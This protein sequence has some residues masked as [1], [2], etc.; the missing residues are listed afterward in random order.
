[1]SNGLRH[2]SQMHAVPVFSYI[3]D[4]TNSSEA[5]EN[6]HQFYQ[7]G[8][9][10]D[11]CLDV[12]YNQ[13]MVKEKH[14]KKTRSDTLN[15]SISSQGFSDDVGKRREYDRVGSCPD[16]GFVTISE[17]NLRT[18]PSHLPPPS[19]PPPVL[20]T[21]MD[22]SSG[23]GSSK[24]S[25]SLEGTEG[26]S[27]PSFFDVEADASS[28]AAAAASSA[29][30]K[31][32]VAKAR[33]QLRNAKELMERKQD[34]FQSRA[35]MTS[36]SDLQEARR[37]HCVDEI[38]KG[39]CQRDSNG[40]K[41]P[42]LEEKQNLAN[43]GQTNPAKT[44]GKELSLPKVAVGLED[45]GVWKEATQ[46]F[47]LVKTKVANSEMD[48]EKQSSESSNNHDNGLEEVKLSEEL[49]RRHENF[50]QKAVKEAQI[51]DVK[52]PRE[53]Q[54]AEYGKPREPQEANIQEDQEKKDKVSQVVCEQEEVHK[55]LN[56]FWHGET[57]NKLNNSVDSYNR[58]RLND[59]QIDVCEFEVRQ[60]MGVKKHYPNLTESSEKMTDEG[61]FWKRHGGKGTI[62]RETVVSE[63]EEE[64]GIFI[65]VLGK[66]EKE[67][68]QQKLSEQDQTERRHKLIQKSVGETATITETNVPEVTNA[69]EDNDG[70]TL[71]MISEQEQREGITETRDREEHEWRLNFDL[72]LA[73]EP[74]GQEASVREETEKR[75]QEGLVR[76]EAEQ[77]LKQVHTQEHRK[78]LSEENERQET[79]KRE[80]EAFQLGDLKRKEEASDHE[81]KKRRQW[82]ALEKEEKEKVLKEVRKLEEKEK[83][84]HKAYVGQEDK[85]RL[86]EA[87]WLEERVREAYEREGTGKVPKTLQQTKENEKNIKEDSEID[88]YH[89]Q[90][91]ASAT[92]EVKANYGQEYEQEIDDALKET[93]ELE[94]IDFE[95]SEGTYFGES[96]VFGE[97]HKKDECKQNNIVGLQSDD[98]TAEIPRKQLETIGA[99]IDEDNGMS[100][101]QSHGGGS[102]EPAVDEKT[103]DGRT[104]LI[105][106]AGEVLE[107]RKEGC[108]IGDS[109]KPLTAN[110][111]EAAPATGIVI[112]G[113]KCQ[114]SSESEHQQG[115][116]SVDQGDKE[117]SIRQ[118][119]VC[120]N[121]ETKEDNFASSQSI[122]GESKKRNR[123]DLLQSAACNTQR[124]FQ[125][126]SETE[127]RKESVNRTV[128]PEEKDAE[129][130]RKDQELE[131]DRLR[132]IEEERER[133]REREKDR[134][135]V[136]RAILEAQERAFSEARER[137]ERA[138]VER[139]AA[140]ARQ[141]S[142][143][144][145]RE[146]LE[147][148]CAEAKERSLPDKDAK[149]R[150]E[151][152]V[153][154]RAM[155]EARQRAAEKTAY[156]G[157]ERVDRSFSDNFSAPR[158]NG[159]RQSSL[160]SVCRHICVLLFGI[161]FKASP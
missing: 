42:L 150:A 88:F 51:V 141:R 23:S 83:R 140:G 153:V 33:A 107:N 17:L 151:R 79:G 113:T 149:T 64:R 58:E 40:V 9:G 12:G 81:E 28:S 124:T 112:E 102:G 125:N 71:N 103:I 104:G 60:L 65:T 156:E 14:L 39:S 159:M 105:V 37:K 145:A 106:S 67:K 6:V 155:A 2:A 41:I 138:A 139:A 108:G 136:D 114:K 77:R 20:D 36:N 97:D 44:Q 127:S 96:G 59:D 78:K 158:Y 128:T 129:R 121:E 30:M 52:E 93:F 73:E 119:E 116:A 109:I 87:W 90:V 70:R 98:L 45:A 55:K 82:Q 46:I 53:Y 38:T 68:G 1:M 48:T 111:L 101:N 26:D 57:L 115:K 84:Q 43:A 18:V 22:Y 157:R 123:M 94:Q 47:E 4:Q 161:T 49:Y 120:I 92:H 8:S 117:K 91:E 69:K 75:L 95:L 7:R 24:K 31:E 5:T 135:A 86:Q 11:G 146:R 16:M 72:D 110:G 35:K 152:A 50:K 80:T 89:R 133:E 62:N 148:L 13:K 118:V 21:K 3:V 147:K 66:S 126:A 63:M 143:I 100:R 137:P 54:E 132:K 122:D 27:S 160:P 99:F 85:N 25:A 56:A 76:E 142:L 131:K 19:R 74:K 61:S 15:G 130:V 144:E 34:G 10:D 134:M 154:E 32:T 29:A